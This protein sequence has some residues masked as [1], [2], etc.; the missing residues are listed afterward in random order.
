MDNPAKAVGSVVLGSAV[1]ALGGPVGLVGAPIVRYQAS[2][3][4]AMSQA[5]AS[6]GEL[7]DISRQR[8]Y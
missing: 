4:K 7:R 5:L 1:A 6:L 2:R 3:M 8:G